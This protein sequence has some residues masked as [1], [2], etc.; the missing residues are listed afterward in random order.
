MGLVINDK[1]KEI[2]SRLIADNFTSQDKIDSTIKGY[3][4]QIEDNKK[5]FFTKFYYIDYEKSIITIKDSEGKEKAQIKLSENNSLY[6]KSDFRKWSD[7]VIVLNDENKKS[8]DFYFKD[9][10]NPIIAIDKKSVPYLYTNDIENFN[11]ISQITQYISNI[12]SKNSLSIYDINFSN[13]FNIMSLS[14]RNSGEIFLIDMINDKLIRSF[15]LKPNSN[16][17]ILNVS[18]SSKNKKVYVTD[19][20]STNLNIFDIDKGEIQNINL[21]LGVLGSIVLT[22]DEKD[23]YVLITKPKPML[24]LIDLTN[25]SS[26]KEFP[27]KG[28]L[29]SLSDYPYDLLSIS[30]DKKFIY[31]MTYIPDPEPFT[32]VITVIETDKE[33]ATQ[34]FSI[35]DKIKISNLSNGIDNP[36]N[37]NKTIFQVLIDNKIIDNDKIE[38]TKSK[39]EQ[40]K[41]EANILKQLDI[42]SN[43]QILEINPGETTLKVPQEE[44]KVEI[45]WQIKDKPQKIEFCNI[46]PGLDE[47]LLEKCFKKVLGDY[48]I[49]LTKLGEEE[50]WENIQK[51]ISIR[52]KELDK[53]IKNKESIVYIRLKDAVVKVRQEIEW[54]D[55]AVIRLIDLMTDYNFEIMFKR[56]ECL[57]WIRE[58]ERDQLIE[59]GLKTIATNCPNCNAQLLGSYTCRAC[60]FELEKPEDAIRRKLLQ[61]A[62]YHPMDNLKQGHLI[63]TDVVNHK[64]IE[65]DHF[66]RIIYELKKDVLHSDLEVELEIP[67]DAVRLKNNITLVVDYGS[68][69]VFKL[70]QKGRKFWELAYDAY[71]EN[72][73]NKPISA[74]ALESGNTVIVDHGNHRVIEVTEDHEIDWSYGKK[75]QSGIEDGLLNSP[76]YFQR[77]KAATNIITDSGNNRI[78]EL[79]GNKIIWQYGNENNIDNDESKGDGFNQLNHPLTAWR[80]ENGNTLILDSGNHRVI[81]VNKEKEVIW[82]YIIPQE[83]NDRDPP[84]KAFR[85]KTGKIM[86]TS[87]KRVVEIDHETKEITWSSSIEELSSTASENDI[88][89]VKENIKKAKVFHGVTSR[90]LS[91][92]NVENKMDDEKMKAYMEAK[93][94]ELANKATSRSPVILTA[95]AEVIDME[96]ITLDKIKSVAN[97]IDRKGNYIWNYGNNSELKKPQ[98]ATF[99]EKNIII[100]DTDNKRILVFD[101]NSGELINTINKPDLVYIKSAEITEDDTLLVC[102]SLGY[103]IVEIDYNGKV[104]YDLKNAELVKAPYYAQKLKNENLLIADWAN[105]RIIEIDKNNQIIW[106]YGD[107][108]SGNEKNQL[109]YPEYAIRLKNQNTLISDTKNSRVIEVNSNNDILWSYEGQGIHKLMSP[110]MSIRLEDGNTVITHSNNRQMVEVDSSGKILW[111]YLYQDKKM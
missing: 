67:R 72:D 91:Q 46:T 93:R 7:S 16:N 36:L 47:I 28:D 69:R 3:S 21:S 87:E 27:V 76:T 111:K 22:P 106:S 64:V 53:K 101:K 59:T 52:Y 30:S 18:I 104:L 43:S 110:T 42:N 34:R 26:K 77:T 92:S 54:H 35:K 2:I 1:E 50:G 80:Y 63:I 17:K 70:T 73:L 38:E 29:F 109:S 40:E 95:G 57:E 5:S 68:N 96:F 60:G 65:T 83:E 8:G 20:L 108:N 12:S 100:C 33:K 55:L 66:R 94:S 10:Y 81:E 58:R 24:K 85:L 79:E 51:E 56:D 39:I 37:A 13:D 98:F 90:Y 107:K 75:G 11:I 48:E 31:L 4:K 97:L 9:D 44:K 86:L 62:T 71:P 88:T 41:N 15:T 14:N 99:N 103:R 32:P 25:N 49:K 89:T 23:L 82:E 45:E 78:I 74:A 102:D 6:N 105:H 19:N 84:V 61:V